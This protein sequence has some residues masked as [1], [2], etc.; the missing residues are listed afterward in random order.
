MA[1]YSA[2]PESDSDHTHY[3]MYFTTAQRLTPVIS[4]IAVIDEER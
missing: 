2:I 3:G 4:A 1:T